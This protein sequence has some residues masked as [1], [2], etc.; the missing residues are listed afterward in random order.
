MRSY[1]I[2][3][4]DEE[5]CKELSEESYEELYGHLGIPYK[6][7]SDGNIE[8]LRLVSYRRFVKEYTRVDK[9]HY[10][11]YCFY[12]AYIL[13]NREYNRRK[14]R[15]FTSMYICRPSGTE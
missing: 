3:T 10:N 1:V 5:I 6:N 15:E 9:D 12:K 13:F 11:I 4:G 8:I 2:M 7:W 14:E